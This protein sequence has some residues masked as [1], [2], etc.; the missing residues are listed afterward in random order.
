MIASYQSFIDYVKCPLNYFE[1]LNVSR[2]YTSDRLLRQARMRISLAHPDKSEFND[3]SEF[4]RLASI[5][6]I[7]AEPLFGNL[8]D[9]FGEFEFSD[10]PKEGDYA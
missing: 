8:Y 10:T 1:S 6:N 4:N 9:T 7:L 5:R 2:A 3:S